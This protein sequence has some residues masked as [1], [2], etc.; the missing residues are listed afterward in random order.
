VLQQNPPLHELLT[1]SSPV[2]QARPIAFL[3]K[4]V[5]LPLQ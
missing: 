4:H 5:A 1:H 3:G 2:A